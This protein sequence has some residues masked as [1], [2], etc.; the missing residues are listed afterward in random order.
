ML[1]HQHKAFLMGLKNIIFYNEYVNC[2]SRDVSFPKYPDSSYY[3][4]IAT[5]I[6]SKYCE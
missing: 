1:T 2:A 6:W 3:I 4:K 5:N